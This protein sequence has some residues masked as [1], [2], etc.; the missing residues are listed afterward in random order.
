M[1]EVKLKEHN[2][3]RKHHNKPV[4]LCSFYHPGPLHKI[5]LQSVYNFLSNDQKHK[6]ETHLILYFVNI[7]TPICNNAYGRWFAPCACHS[8]RL[9]H[10]PSAALW[11]LGSL[12]IS[13]KEFHE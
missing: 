8:V 10:R 2:V 13:H 11:L 9:S 6:L 7:I 3:P 5:S 1:G 4:H 12:R